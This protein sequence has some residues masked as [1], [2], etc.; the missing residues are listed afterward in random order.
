MFYSHNQRILIS[1]GIRKTMK[2]YFVD[3][4]ALKKIWFGFLLMDQKN[5]GYITIVHLMDA[6]NERTYSILA[7]FIERFYEL[8]DKDDKEKKNVT[9]DEFLPAI[10]AFALFTRQEMIA[11]IFG[12][13]DHTKNQRITKVDMLRFS[14]IIRGGKKINTN[15]INLYPENVETNI[16]L[17]KFE[18]GDEIDLV[19]FTKCAISIPYFVFPAFRL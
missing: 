2:D 6:L 16:A 13:L 10:C 1:V 15:L 8:I 4:D 17:Y 3:E 18:R 12:M 5:R 19:E 9:F 7:P 14:S 11:F